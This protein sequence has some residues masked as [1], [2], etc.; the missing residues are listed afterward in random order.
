MHKISML[1]LFGLI[2]LF[3]CSVSSENWND[4]IDAKSRAK[5]KVLDDKII[6]ALHENNPQKLKELF[7]DELKRNSGNQIDAFVEKIHGSFKTKN[8][9]ILDE[10]LASN[11]AIGTTGTAMKGISGEYD[12][13]ISYPVLTKETYISL[14]LDNGVGNKHL[15][16][17]IFGKYGSDWKLTVLK[18]G[19]YS[20]FGKNAIDFYKQAEENYK[21]GNLV[22]AANDI[23]MINQTATPAD[24]V[25]HYQN[26]EAM[27]A[28]ANKV[29]AEVNNKFVFPIKVNEI[30]TS[31][32]ILNVTPTPMAEGIYPT[33]GYL[34]KIALDDTIA[35]KRENED[36]R[37]VI[38][39]IFPGIE[40]GKKYIFFKA[41]NEIPNGK[42]LTK[43]YGFVFNILKQ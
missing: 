6:E 2:L 34:S 27:S 38:G 36:L 12:Y 1:L 15:V 10:Y 40:K 37:K 8:Y 20:F 39:D 19:D 23:V 21:R 24:D 32:Q 18:I 5:I 26:A 31:P 11:P 29:W 42:D 41:Y 7:S 13:K 22:D 9:T 33:V 30:K 25:F 14:L 35:L 4:H 17:C 28:F 3:G 43:S 16:T